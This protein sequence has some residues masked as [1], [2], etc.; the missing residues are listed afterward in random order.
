MEYI[1]RA[2][3]GLVLQTAR[4]YS[5]VLVTGPRQVGKSTMLEH[6]LNQVGDAS[7]A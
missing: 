2:M 1:L 3:E 6:V 5:A 7:S 4:E